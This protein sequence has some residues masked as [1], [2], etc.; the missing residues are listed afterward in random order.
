MT[1][2]LKQKW[3]DALRSEKYVQGQGCLRSVKNKYCC[4][5]V[6]CDVFGSKRW[7]KLTRT[8]FVLNTTV[9]Y[10]Y[11]YARNQYRTDAPENIIKIVDIK[12]YLPLR[13]KEKIKTHYFGEILDGIHF[14]NLNDVFE[15][16]F[17]EIADVIEN[18]PCEKL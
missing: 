18:I 2:E 10:T 11:N 3:I 13:I 15:L 1:K 17:N 12:E 9:G 5:G 8:D 7:K 16:S 6:L 4:L 14:I